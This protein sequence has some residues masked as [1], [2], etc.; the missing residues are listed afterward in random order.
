MAIS[1]D[2]GVFAFSSGATNLITNDTN[3][4]GDVFVHELC[5]LPGAWSNYDAGLAGT[6][7][8][9]TLTSGQPPVLGG[10]IDVNVGNSLG[11]PTMGVLVIGTAQASFH[12]KFGADL[13]VA[14]SLI[15][16]IT[17]SYGGDTF[18]GTIPD[19][20]DYCGTFVELQALELDPGAPFGVS[21]TP[22]LELAI[23]R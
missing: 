7:G 2:G 6:Q 20:S 17:F 9:P 11:A 16:P 10:S 23:G 14:P 19:D 8:I 1:A 4:F 15:V 12:T 18:S 3:G 22:G 21:F 13:L 5:S